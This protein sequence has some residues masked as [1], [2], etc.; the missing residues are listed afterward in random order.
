MATA[1]SV[2]NVDHAAAM[3]NDFLRTGIAAL[4]AI[5]WASAVIDSV[6][7][8]QYKTLEVVTPVMMIVTG[9]LFGYQITVNR[10]AGRNRRKEDQ[11]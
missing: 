3:K 10:S 6:V 4:V 9:F 11:E 5:C 1:A 2:T 8:T 7:T